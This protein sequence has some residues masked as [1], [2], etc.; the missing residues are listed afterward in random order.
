LKFDFIFLTC[1]KVWGAKTKSA[2]Q[3]MVIN[4]Q[5]I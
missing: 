3:N 5:H 4:V 2:V 1:F